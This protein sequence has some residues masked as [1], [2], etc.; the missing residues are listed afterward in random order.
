V[1]KSAKPAVRKNVRVQTNGA[2]CRTNAV[3]ELNQW[4]EPTTNVNVRC[5]IVQQQ[6]QSPTINRTTTNQ[7]TRTIGIITTIT[8]NNNDQQQ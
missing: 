2:A 3:A 5:V 4:S 7:L 8:V 6:Q 1:Q